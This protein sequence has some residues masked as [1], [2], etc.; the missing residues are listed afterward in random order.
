MPLGI[1]SRRSK[2]KCPLGSRPKAPGRDKAGDSLR[3]QKKKKTL[4]CF[5]IQF[6][7]E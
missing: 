7:G 3:Y 2:I 5:D 4:G 1:G 6:N